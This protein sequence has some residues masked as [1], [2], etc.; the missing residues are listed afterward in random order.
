MQ[1]NNDQK[2]AINQLKV[3]D[4]TNNSQGSLA[5]SQT[6][7][8]PQSF[9]S[10]SLDYESQASMEMSLSKQREL[11]SVIAALRRDDMGTESTSSSIWQAAGQSTADPSNQVTSMFLAQLFD[12]TQNVVGYS[13]DAAAKKGQ[14]AITD[15]G[16]K[17]PFNSMSAKLASLSNLQQDAVSESIEQSRSASIAASLQ[18]SQLST[19]LSLLQ[20]SISQSLSESASLAS[21]QQVDSLAEKVVRPNFVPELA[22]YSFKEAL[23]NKQ[24]SVEGQLAKREQVVPAVDLK[25]DKQTEMVEL[26]Q[27]IHRTIIFNLPSGELKTEFQTHTFTRRGKKNLQTGEVTW[28]GWDDQRYVLPAY[29]IPNLIGY[30]HYPANIPPL[31]VY[32]NGKDSTVQVKYKLEPIK[33]PKRIKHFGEEQPAEKQPAIDHHKLNEDIKEEAVKVEP[34]A[35]TQQNKQNEEKHFSFLKIIGL[36]IVSMF[37]F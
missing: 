4:H 13:I 34:L 6:A 11:S 37:I 27:K 35:R 26:R 8:V 9:T 3:A 5:S 23:S 19:S 17:D 15:E 18:H 21:R 14:Q 22:E 32:P 31:V 7:E 20:D 29:V 28:L 1:N 12:F 24:P 16:V 36:A 33:K 2:D 25:N 30:Q 10:H